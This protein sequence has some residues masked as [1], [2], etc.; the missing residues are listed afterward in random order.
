[1]GNWNTTAQEVNQVSSDVEKDWCIGQPRELD[2][3]DIGPAEV[4]SGW[5]DKS[6]PLPRWSALVVDLDYGYLDDP[7]HRVIQTGR[8]YVKAGEY[9]LGHA[10]AVLDWDAPA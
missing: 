6:R 3:V 10:P 5:V 2:T 1:V 4:S 9:G 7:A 8:F